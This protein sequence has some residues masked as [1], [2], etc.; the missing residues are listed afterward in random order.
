MAADLDMGIDDIE[1]LRVAVN[2]LFALLVGPSTGPD[3]C[4]DLTFTSDGD[5]VTVE[6]SR[7]AGA[8]APVPEIDPLAVEILRV[9][10]D[11]HEF[12]ADGGR[13]AFRMVK[14]VRAAT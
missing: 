9:V 4:V 7:D 8:D 5:K 2:E 14:G 11:E 13:L 1:D 3:D 10:A 12:S 6:G